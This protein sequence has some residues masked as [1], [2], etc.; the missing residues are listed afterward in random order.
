MNISDL[1]DSPWKLAILA[2]VLIVFFGSTRLPGAARSLGRSM[3]IL[4]AEMS[5]LH[6]EDE[7]QDPAAPPATF[8]VA[9][10]A[11]SPAL[12][13]AQQQLEELQRQVREL[14]QKAATTQQT[15]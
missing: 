9:Q 11:A 4:K 10:A 5:G 1:F 13:S 14:Q 6:K 8:P 15:S 7:T 2:V 3:R 12:P